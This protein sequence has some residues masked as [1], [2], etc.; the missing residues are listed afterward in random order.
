MGLV[1]AVLAQV[2]IATTPIGPPASGQPPGRFPIVF[3][4]RPP[5]DMALAGAA[6]PAQ[7]ISAKRIVLSSPA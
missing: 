2:A 7:P 3:S 5:A 6:T 4:T 1:E